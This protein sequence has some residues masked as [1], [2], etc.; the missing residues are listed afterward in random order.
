[1]QVLIIHDSETEDEI[2][3]VTPL[4]QIDFNVFDD[5][6][7]ATWEK[8]NNDGLANDCSIEDFVTFHNENSD[9][10]IDYVVSDF[11]QL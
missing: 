8:F 6:V 10:V 9:L 11:I 7:R 5:K 3:M 2:G 1:M 4:S